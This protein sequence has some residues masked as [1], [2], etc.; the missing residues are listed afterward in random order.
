MSFLTKYG[1]HTC[2]LLQ[3]WMSVS[4]DL[5]SIHG[6]L[7]LSGTACGFVLSPFSDPP[8]SSLFSLLY[9]L[10]CSAWQCCSC[11][12][13]A[14]V[15]TVLCP[16]HVPLLPPGLAPCS[17][18]SLR[19]GKKVGVCPHHRQ[20]CHE[21]GSAPCPSLLAAPVVCGTS[22]IWG[23]TNPFWKWDSPWQ[24]SNS[25]ELSCWYLF[26]TKVLRNSGQF[27]YRFYLGAFLLKHLA[28]SFL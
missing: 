5:K 1:G 22:G 18:S 23:R 24:E 16:A 13:C 6:M 2:P 17:S 26:G 15:L 20:S 12:R 27:D 21:A 14:L 3:T 28:K 11:R 9:W 25:G 19:Q 8:S 10:G 4:S 7:L